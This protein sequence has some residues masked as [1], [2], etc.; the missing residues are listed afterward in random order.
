LEDSLLI[1]GR[2]L[3]KDFLKNPKK[4][5]NLGLPKVGGVWGNLLG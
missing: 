3:I 2:L 1:R 5:K 4:V